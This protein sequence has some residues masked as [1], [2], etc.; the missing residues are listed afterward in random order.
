MTTPGPVSD[1]PLPRTLID[2]T[3]GSSFAA[4]AANER[5]F[6]AEAETGEQAMVTPPSDVVLL[7]WSS[8][9]PTPTPPPPKTSAARPAA[10]AGAS[11]AGRRRAADWTGSEGDGSG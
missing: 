3:D 1:P 6:A 11:Q 9:T 5:G 8:A 7:S 2:T 10:A 4:I